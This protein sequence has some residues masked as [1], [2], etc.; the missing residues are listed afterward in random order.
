M[1]NPLFPILCAALFAASPVRAQEPPAEADYEA[2]LTEAKGE[3]MVF[4]VEEP[5]GV[6]GDKD[7]PLAAGDRV[8]TGEDSSAEIVFSGEHCVSLR[9]RSELTLTALRRQDSELSLALGSLLAKI[10]SLTGGDFRVRTSAA[11]ASVRG[12]E[13][14]V[15]VDNEDPSQTHVGVFDEGKVAVT[16]AGGAPELLKANQE[17]SVRRGGRPMAAYQLKRFTRQRQFMRGFRK[18]AQAVRKAWRPLAAGQRQQKRREMLQRL[19]QQRQQRLQKLQKARV[20]KAQ[21]ARSPR[22]DQQKME[23]RKRAIRDRLRGGGN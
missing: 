14:G 17:T 9:S 12:T 5:E 1:K 23:Q 22:A 15:E 7:M 10:Q 19:K 4:T 21:K 11:V 16:G 6:P 8:K 18:R 13:F 2:R 20:P 3:V